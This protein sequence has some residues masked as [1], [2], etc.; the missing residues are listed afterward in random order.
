LF[1]QKD[2][3]GTYT[4]NL[5]D[6]YYQWLR[7]YIETGKSHVGIYGSFEPN[8]WRNS[9]R[10]KTYPITIVWSSTNTPVLNIIRTNT[11]DGQN[12]EWTTSNTKSLSYSCIANWVIIKGDVELNRSKNFSSWINLHNA[13]WV[14]GK[15]TCIWKA[16]GTSTTIEKAED[17]LIL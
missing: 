7:S 1:W 17:F 6:P 16:V 15:Y 8:Y 12:V 9:V 5:S 10:Y 3:N 11:S 14:A 2:K 4:A 13:G